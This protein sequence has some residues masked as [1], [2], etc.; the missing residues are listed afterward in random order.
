M[1]NHRLPWL[2]ILSLLALPAFSYEYGLTITDDSKYI[3][4]D[5]SKFEQNN[6]AI[7]WFG[8]PSGP[9]ADLYISAFYEFDGNFSEDDSEVVP[10]RVDFGRTEYFGTTVLGPGLLRFHVGR[11][12]VQDYSTRVIS[13]LSDGFKTEYLLGNTTF[14]LTSGYRGLLYKEEA[15]SLI[16][17]DDAAI[18]ADD[19][20]YF[21]PKRMY[22]GAGARVNEWLPY[23][24]LGLE[25][26]AQW[27]LG[28]GDYTTH[29]QYIEPY[30]D[31]RIGRSIR[32]R[33]WG[34]VEFAQADSEGVWA[35]ASGL[36]VRYSVPELKNL[37]V[38]G[39]VIWASGDNGSPTGFAP[40]RQSTM[41]TVSTLPFSDATAINLDA[42]LTPKRGFN[43]GAGGS[44]LFRASMDPPADGAIRDDADGYYLGSEATIRASVKPTS[45][46][47]VNTEA[48]VFIP[49]TSLYVS[50]TPN[51][52]S[53]GLSFTFEL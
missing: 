19:D 27:D 23:H 5:E 13:S 33:G 10:W 47:S 29:S 41:A 40:I 16:D 14:L 53:L 12:E 44:A 11:I 15:N 45:D 48:G 24:D 9:T 1:R 25:A 43:I 38:T 49:N 30:V 6:R 39:N 52:W 21:G 8:M 42:D 26:W 28:D 51:R 3:Y 2:L 20:E 36:R 32:W 4:E 46:L 17:P 31:G 18:S 50:D 35:L 7:L 22:V 34:I 37:H